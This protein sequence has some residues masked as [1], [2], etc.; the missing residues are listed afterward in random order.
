MFYK[1]VIQALNKQKIRYA[2]VGGLAVNLHGATRGTL[3]M[4][5]ITELTLKNLKSLEAC[6]KK[7]GLRPKLPISAEDLYHYRQEYIDKRNLVAW[8]FVASDNPSQVI[9]IVITHDLCEFET[10]VIRAGNVPFTVINK[11]ALI[12]M[13]MQSGRKQDLEDIKALKK[14]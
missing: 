3:G 5:L 7:L 1:S 13:K 11:N 9:D 8:S 12:D 10:T 4:D 2:V 14:L 6:M